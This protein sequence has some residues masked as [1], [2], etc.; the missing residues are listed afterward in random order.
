MALRKRPLHSLLA[1]EVLSDELNST[2]LEVQRFQS[3]IDSGIHDKGGIIDIA[4]KEEGTEKENHEIVETEQENDH[5]DGEA[6]E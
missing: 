1:T 3:L 4:G 5:E 2:L 6:D